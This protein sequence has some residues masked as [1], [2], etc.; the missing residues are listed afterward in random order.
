MLTNDTL[1][2]DP[3]Y[4]I[5]FTEDGTSLCF[6]VHGAALQ[7][8]NL[9]SDA[10]TNVIAFYASFPLV[11]D[12]LNFVEQIGVRA[13]GNSGSCYN[14]RVY[15]SD[16]DGFQ[17]IATVDNTTVGLSGI[18]IDGIRVRQ[19]MDRVRISVPNCENVNLVM[20]VTCELRNRLRMLRFD[21]SRGLTLRPTSHGLIGKCL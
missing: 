13:V 20:W 5:P 12:D 11:D 2:G 14:I 21:V 7:Y 10:C 6:E 17:C 4:A 1:V 8:F 9:I 15:E 3:L 18:E 19:I 16:T